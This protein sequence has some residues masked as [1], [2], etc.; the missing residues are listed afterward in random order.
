MGFSY[1]SQSKKS[2]VFQGFKAV[3]ILYLFGTI[4]NF[5]VNYRKVLRNKQVIGFFSVL[6]TL[7]MK[8][9]GLEYTLYDIIRGINKKGKKKNIPNVI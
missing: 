4:T 1:I 3:A 5:P 9:K 2:K 6:G 7:E 8:L